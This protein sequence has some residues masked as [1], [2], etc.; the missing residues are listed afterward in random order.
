MNA[1][2][3]A[4]PIGRLVATRFVRKRAEIP[5]DVRV[6]NVNALSR[7]ARIVEKIMSPIRE[8]REVP[9]TVRCFV[10][11]TALKRLWDQ[12]ETTFAAFDVVA[13]APVRE[14]Y[15]GSQYLGGHHPKAPRSQWS[16]V[17]SG[18][19]MCADMGG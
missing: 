14:A 8:G 1:M 7:A 9:E 18:A 5:A 6:H 19:A 10:S 11:I 16:G 12:C 13:A 2:T 3:S 15:D 4:K 17:G